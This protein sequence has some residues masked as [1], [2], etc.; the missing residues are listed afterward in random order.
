MSLQSPAPPLPQGPQGCGGVEKLRQGGGWR[1]SGWWCPDCQHLYPSPGLVQPHSANRA[2]LTTLLVASLPARIPQKVPIRHPPRPPS[3]RQ[4]L[5]L[6]QTLTRPAGM[7]DRLATRPTGAL[8][9]IQQAVAFLAHA[10]L[11]KHEYEANINQQGI[12][13][14]KHQLSGC[15]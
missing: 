11:L 14:L 10:I 1:T 2:T 13:T 6:H 7:G 4:P 9:Q 3:V 15:P 5:L 12:L 8:V